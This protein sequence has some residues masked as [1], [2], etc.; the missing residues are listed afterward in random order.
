MSTLNVILLILSL[1]SPVLYAG[2]SL[3]QILLESTQEKFQ[4]FPK[5]DDLFV[6]QNNIM[7]QTE[8][9]YNLL[10]DEISTYSKMEIE[11]H[12]KA[13]L[14]IKNNPDAFKKDYFKRLSDSLSPKEKR[15]VT[16]LAYVQVMM[17]GVIGIIAAL[18]ESVSN[19]NM[20]E[21][22]KKSLSQRWIEDVKKGPVIDNDYWVINYIGHPISGS[23]YYVWGRSR[24][25]NWKESAVLSTLMSTVFWEY[26][27]E[28]FLEVPSL[29]D[30]IFTPL[31]GSIIGEGAFYLYN[32]IIKND[33]KIGNSKIL[34]NIARGILNPIG[35]INMHIDS[36][37]KKISD[38]VKVDTQLDLRYS[39][40]YN[41]EYFNHHIN[42]GK[43]DQNY[44]GLNFNF[45]F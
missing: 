15:L 7:L 22:N 42:E 20:A 23:A 11:A 8:S 6:G 16:D 25:L 24:G 12:N 30:L 40:S 2:Q 31:I 34:G 29:Q 39:N 19:W 26:G 4:Y 32:K 44:I 18:P 35:E 13:Y 27:Y 33:G 38:N 10:K 41:K 36:L 17:V 1:F 43:I 14:A 21:L 9:K 45:N 3:E 28:A 5:N 37:V